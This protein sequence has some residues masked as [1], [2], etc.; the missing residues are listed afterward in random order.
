MFLLPHFAGVYKFKSKSS[1]VPDVRHPT[2]DLW[3]L[4]FLLHRGG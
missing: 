3:H 1:D 2:S 4:S